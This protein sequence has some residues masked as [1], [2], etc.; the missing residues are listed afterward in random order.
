[1]DDEVY[2][3]KLKN[4]D[5]ILCNVKIDAHTVFVSNAFQ[6][7][8]FDVEKFYSK[9]WLAFSKDGTCEINKTDLLVFT[10][11][12]DYALDIFNDIQKELKK[13]DQQKLLIEE[14]LAELMSDEST[15]H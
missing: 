9:P 13:A 14:E 4:G 15:V 11:A 10:K 3:M 1:M 5:D 8:P 2:Y 7:V 6:I 12:S